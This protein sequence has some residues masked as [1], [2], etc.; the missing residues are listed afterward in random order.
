MPLRPSRHLRLALFT[1]AA[2]CYER[3]SATPH[4]QLNASFTARIENHAIDAV[5]LLFVV[6]NSNS[7]QPYQ[8]RLG[9][10]FGVLIDQL[11]NPPRD[12]T[13]G[14]PLRPPVRSLHLAVVSTDLG[15]PGT[16]AIG[17]CDRANDVGDDGLLNPIRSGAAMRNHRPWT[18]LPA[19]ARPE[20]C[21]QNPDQYPTFLTFDADTSDAAAFREDFVC[22]AY[23]STQGCGLEQ[24]LESAYRALVVHNPR[25]TPGNM[26]PNAGFVRDDAVLGVVVISDEEDGSVRDCRYAEAGQPCDDALSVY[27]PDATRWAPT[28]ELNLRFYQY[29]PGSPQ[30]P[31]WP[32]DRYVDTTNARRGFPSLKPDHPERV[33]FAG[34]VGVPLDIPTRGGR[35]DWGALLGNSP[36]GAD[37]VESANA[38][39]PYTMRPNRA[40]PSC[41]STRMM[42]ACRA[43]TSG[44]DPSTLSCGEPG[45]RYAWPSRRIAQV[46]RRFDEAWNSGAVAS[47]CA[48]DYRPAL[49]QIVDRI[50][51]AIGGRCL[52][53]ALPTSPASPA[54]GELTRV[55]CVVRET[56]PAGA[57]CEAAHGRY[58]AERTADGRAVCLVDQVAVPF[59]GAPPAGAHGFFYDTRPDPTAPDCAQRVAFTDGDGVAREGSAQVDCVA[60][61]SES[62]ATSS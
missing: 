11:V 22:N 32:I 31:T 38:Q 25:A 16:T 47:I 15:T 59:G 28:R 46:A 54:P 48:D 62:S 2:G 61:A 36:D 21:T 52:P 12:A 3:P 18:T 60:V 34:I 40:D 56:L 41:P 42:P 55:S 49:Q 27:D 13:S 6:D 14:L 37:A 19:D 53:R 39:G 35:T 30:D 50:G 57:Q 7:M 5:D 8:A 51:N 29:T 1:L 20:R 17:T 24:Q 58:L 44:F 9:E 26:D 43:Q 4:N 10:Q 33:I 23:L 45:P